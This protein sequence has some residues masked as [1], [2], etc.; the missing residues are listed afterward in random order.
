MTVEN[1]ILTT[2]K[3]SVREELNREANATI[4]NLCHK[5]RCE[6]GKHKNELVTEILNRIDIEMKNN[7][8]DKDVVF[9]IT[10]KG[11]MNNAE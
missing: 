2:L 6:L 9:Q 11:G 3:N 10:I 7:C 4:E 5:F 8:G 1:E